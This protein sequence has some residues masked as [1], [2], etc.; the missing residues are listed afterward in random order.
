[1]QKKTRNPTKKKKMKLCTRDHVF[2]FGK[3]TIRERKLKGI[4][5]V[6]CV[7]CD[8]RLVAH[9][10]TSV[11]SEETIESIRKSILRMGGVPTI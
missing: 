11:L 2:K 1:M 7:L 9:G 8:Y 6:E 4:Q 3:P 5:I 10:D